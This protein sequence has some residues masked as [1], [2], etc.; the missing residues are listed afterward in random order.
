MMATYDIRYDVTTEQYETILENIK[1]LPTKSELKCANFGCGPM[2]WEG[3]E[4]YDK[5]YKHPK[6]VNVDMCDESLDSNAFDIVFSSHSLEHNYFHL[7]KKTILNWKRILQQGGYIHLTV[8]DLENTM[9][10]ILDERTSF[11]LKYDWYIYTLFGYQTAPEIG[12]KQRSINDPVDHG[13][14][15]YCGFT[16]EW[17]RRFFQENGF[18]IEELVSFNGYDTPSLYMKARKL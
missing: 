15:H 10:F 9:K 6:V 14:I 18:V 8:P 4:S 13:Q 11:E 5:Y 12:W 7:A 3:W 2:I 1:K 17:L 16:K